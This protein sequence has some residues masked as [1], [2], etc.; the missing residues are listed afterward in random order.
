MDK[1]GDEKGKQ[2][3]LCL[4]AFISHILTIFCFAKEQS[5]KHRIYGMSGDGQQSTHQRYLVCADLEDI[6]Y[7]FKCC[8]AKGYY[9]SVN[10]RIKS[11]VKVFIVPCD[12]SQHQE[13][14]ALFPQC[15]D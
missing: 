5:H 14:K 10:D 9:Y 4:S 3:I 6:H 2:H 15:D 8:K 13:L 7:V 1:H 11:I 12:S